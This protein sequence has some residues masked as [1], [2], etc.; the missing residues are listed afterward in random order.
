MEKTFTKEQIDLIVSKRVNETKEAIQK[1]M[2]SLK[3][4]AENWD[5]HEASIK[6]AEAQAKAKEIEEKAKKY[7]ELES[8]AKAFD[9]YQAN[10]GKSSGGVADIPVTKEA[11]NDDDLTD[12]QKEKLSQLDFL[13][14]KEQ[15]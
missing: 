9:E 15:E 12:S 10:L 8:K 4:K 6:E 14:K 3:A 1:E 13:D 11:K 5:K 2:D 7:A